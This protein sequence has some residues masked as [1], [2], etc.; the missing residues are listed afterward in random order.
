MFV[1]SLEILIYLISTQIMSNVK[2]LNNEAST[3]F[4]KNKIA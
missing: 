2:C 1:L 4:I 3:N